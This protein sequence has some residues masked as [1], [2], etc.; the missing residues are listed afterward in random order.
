MKNLILLFTISLISNAAFSQIALQQWNGGDTANGSIYRNGNVGINVTSVPNNEKLVIGGSFFNGG[1]YLRMGS[2]VSEK[3]R[4]FN[5]GI[6]PSNQIGANYFDSEGVLRYEF[7]AGETTSLG[8]KDTDASEIFKM[9]TDPEIGAFMHLPKKNSRL[10]VGD[11]GSYLLND[12]HKLVVKAGSAMIEGNILTNANIGIGTDSFEDGGEQYRLSVN[13]RMRAEAVKVYTDWADYVFEEDYNLPTLEEV[14]E[15]IN[16]NGHLKD[17]PSA[18]AV[19][20]NGIELGEMNKLLL[21]KVEELTL[22]VIELN[23]EIDNLKN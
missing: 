20:E 18:K 8:L 21:Q 22:Y 11:F 5:F 4:N 23:K 10:V 15:F 9:A 1:H 19:K 3:S 17:I 13:G 12:G 14:E 7:F 16:E 6:S 2:I